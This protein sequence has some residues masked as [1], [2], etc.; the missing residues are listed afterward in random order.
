MRDFRSSI[1]RR[2]LPRDA[3]PSDSCRLIAAFLP[4]WRPSSSY[5][6]SPP[7]LEKLQWSKLEKLAS[8]ASWSPIN[9]LPWNPSNI[10]AEYGTEGCSIGP[11]L[12]REVLA[13][14]TAGL[15]FSSQNFF[16]YKVRVSR[17]VNFS[18]GILINGAE[19]RVPLQPL[20]AIFLVCEGGFKGALIG[21]HDAERI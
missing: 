20:G 12:C 17:T 10:I 19:V 8:L 11:P 6:S 2:L 14:Q 4:V 7:S 16:T 21:P 15:K 9:A 18:I 5:P 1:W 3:S 13:S